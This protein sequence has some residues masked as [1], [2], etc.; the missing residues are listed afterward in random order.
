MSFSV[1]VQFKQQFVNMLLILFDGFA[2]S[3]E[4]VAQ[5]MNV[6]KRE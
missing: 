2:H 5:L 3:H 1:S 6:R 4:H